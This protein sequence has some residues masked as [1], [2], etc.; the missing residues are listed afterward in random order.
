MAKEKVI[1]IG[2]GPAGIMAAGK[3]AEQG[4]NVVLIEKNEKLGKKLFITGKGRCNLTNACPIEEMIQN[5]PVNGKFLRN[6]LFQFG[7]KE[8]VEFF[9]K[10]GLETKVE[11]GERVFPQSDKSSDVIKAL[12][13]YLEQNQVE[14]LHQEV[15]RV[16]KP[17][18]FVLYLANQK[19]ME[20]D[21]LII[22]T[23]G[24]SYPSTGSTGDGYDFAR[25]LGHTITE[26]KPSLVPLEIKEKWV[27]G[28]TGLTLKN[29]GICIKNQNQKKVYSDFGEMEFMPFGVSGPMVLSASAAVRDLDAGGY[30]L[31]ID[32]KPALSEEALE[33]RVQKDFIKYSTLAFGKSLND[34]LPQK[35]IPVIIELSEID[36]RKLVNQIR[37]EERKRLVWLLKNLKMEIKGYRP[38]SEAIITAGGVSLKEI[39]PKTMESKIVPG[40]FFAGEVLDLDGYTGGFNL[41]IAFT[42]GVSAGVSC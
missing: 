16:A 23:G 41:Q 32:L 9:D 37:K 8:L 19:K 36:D 26:L 17:D 13:R 7:N 1:V 33:A 12:S 29:T 22:A 6:A 10:L 21:K 30:S 3:A 38:V 39:N 15:L 14:I 42:T 20:A 11:R 5:I 24:L 35:M 18:R 31:W 2:G 27:S 28:L 25:S 34:L 4:K 40:L